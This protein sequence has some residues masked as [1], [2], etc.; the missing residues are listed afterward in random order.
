MSPRSPEALRASLDTRLL[1]LA[2]EQGTDVN[3]LRRHL[4]FQRLLRRLAHDGRWVLKGGYLLEARL[5]SRARA[6]RDL[7]LTAQEPLDD[8]RDAIVDAMAEDIDGDGFVFHVTRA[9]EHLVD[10]QE[11]GGPGMHLSISANLAGKPFTQ[12]RLDVVARPGEVSGGVEPVRLPVVVA[13]LDWEP[14][15]VPAVDLAQHL[16]EKFHALTKLFAHPR[17]STRV[18]D[19]LDITLLA[20]AGLV[21][22]EPLAH[23]LLAVFGARDAAAPL[24]DLPDPPAAWTEEYASMASEHDVAA[25]TLPAALDL[26]RGIYARALIH[27]P[28][29]EIAQ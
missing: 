3:R 8:L 9:R 21:E 17:P 22:A 15:V 18:K 13:E 4:T 24:P 12:I 20:E 7:D 10:S 28:T 19:L 1:L 16:A 29:E 27:L 6:T 5:G 11:A 23:R 14:V 26:A 25:G 2:Q